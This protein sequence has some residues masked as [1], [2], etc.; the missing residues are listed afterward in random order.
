MILNWR[1]NYFPSIENERRYKIKIRGEEEDVSSLMQKIG[2]ICG[3]PS[4][5]DDEDYNWMLYVYKVKSDVKNKITTILNDMK[6][7][8][9]E[10]PDK[11]GGEGTPEVPLSRGEGPAEEKEDVI[12]KPVD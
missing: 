9:T 5:L 11:K 6:T 10:T 2:D 7:A 12:S 1:M 4:Q 8:E 3:K